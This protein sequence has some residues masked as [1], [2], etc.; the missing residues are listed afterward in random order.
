[1]QGNVRNSEALSR[2]SRKIQKDTKISIANCS[3]RIG[4]SQGT[5]IFYVLNKSAATK[6]VK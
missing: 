3:S 1:M 2:P 6:I 5:Q 4:R